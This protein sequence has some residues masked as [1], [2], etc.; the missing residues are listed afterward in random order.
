MWRLS[1][2]YDNAHMASAGE[3]SDRLQYDGECARLHCE[4]YG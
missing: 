1:L 2:P 4:G 3:W